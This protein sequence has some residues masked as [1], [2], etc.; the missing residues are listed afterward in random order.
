MVVVVLRCRQAAHADQG[1][2]LVIVQVCQRG[3]HGVLLCLEFLTGGKTV[4]YIHGLARRV[5]LRQQ[6]GGQRA[7]A[8]Q[9]GDDGGQRRVPP[10][11]RVGRIRAARLRGGEARQR[12]PR[13]LPGGIE[14]QRGMRELLAE[15]VLQRRGDFG[16]RIVE[17]D[18]GVQQRAPL[19]APRQHCHQQLDQARRVVVHPGQRR[20][21]RGGVLLTIGAVFEMFQRAPRR[22]AVV[23]AG[24]FHRRRLGAEARQ[25]RH[26]PRQSGAEGIDGG[27]A[28]APRLRFDLPA[29]LGRAGQRSPGEIEGEPLVRRLGRHA[30]ARAL[31][32]FGDALAHFAG[33]LVGEGDG[34]DLFG[35]VSNRQQPQVALGQQLGLAGAGR[36]LDD[37]GVEF[38]RAAAIGVVF[39]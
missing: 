37:E 20:G 22:L 6:E 10:G 21:H 14:R 12:H 27:Q 16:L 25:Q 38:E 32:A 19:F 24:I 23:P 5:V 7:P 35:L 2:D 33:R 8:R 31:Q 28:Q 34:D 13:R 36:R 18:R 30:A 3:E 4:F 11:Q 9:V 26:L 1:G 15:Y 39:A 17:R 29:A